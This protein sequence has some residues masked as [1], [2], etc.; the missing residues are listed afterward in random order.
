LQKLAEGTQQ[1]NA[2]I[3]YT[4]EQGNDYMDLYGRA[5]VDIAIDLI[6]GYLLC[7]QASS[8]VDMDVAIAG[9]DARN[10][11]KIP[12]RQRKAR[13]ARRYIEANA[14]RIRSLTDLVRRGDKSTFNEYETV[15]GPVPEA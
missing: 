3:A 9:G 5:L 2:A 11:Q 1:L 13:L 8:D 7:G 4:K 6:N 15:V 14:T 12:M 10:G